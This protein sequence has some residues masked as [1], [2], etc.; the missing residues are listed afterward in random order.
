MLANNLL[1]NKEQL[2]QR[3]RKTAIDWPDLVFTAGANDE[4]FQELTVITLR[5]LYDTKCHERAIAQVPFNEHTW[6]E[7]IHKRA[8]EIMDEGSIRVRE[9]VAVDK[10]YK[11][12]VVID[13]KEV[14]DNTINKALSMLEQSKIPGVT[15]FGHFVAFTSVQMEE[16]YQHC[17]EIKEEKINASIKPL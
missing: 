7:D 11:T 17:R 14:N 2:R 8:N 15:Y 13:D 16:Y 9:M 5:S 3:V 10:G 6:E 1:Y 4:P 12:L